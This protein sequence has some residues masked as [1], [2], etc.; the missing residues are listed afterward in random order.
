MPPKTPVTK[1]TQDMDTSGYATDQ[2]QI[3]RSTRASS[4]VTQP[5]M[6][7]TALDFRI[8]LTKPAN[9]PAAVA[10]SSKSGQSNAPSRVNPKKKRIIED[11]PSVAKA[12][13]AI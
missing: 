9:G 11:D 6:V 4:A 1:S 8:Q 2:S 12:T 3:R 13:P 10:P 7:A 5:N